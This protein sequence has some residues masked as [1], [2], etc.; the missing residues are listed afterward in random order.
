LIQF[1]VDHTQILPH[2]MLNGTVY[3]MVLC[4]AVSIQAQYSF[5]LET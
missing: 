2:V 5:K 1:R 4:Q 3:L